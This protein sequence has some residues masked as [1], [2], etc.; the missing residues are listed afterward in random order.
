[1]A[2]GPPGGAG[3][4][5]RKPVVPSFHHQGGLG[6]DLGVDPP[7][8]RRAGVFLGKDR[9]HRPSPQEP[10]CHHRSH[11]GRH[12]PRPHRPRGV[13]GLSPS[14]EGVQGPGPGEDQGGIEGKEIADEAGEHAP[15]V[16]EV[17]RRKEQKGQGGEGAPAAPH[18]EGPPPD[19]RPR[20][21]GQEGSQ[22][23]GEVFQEEQVGGGSQELESVRHQ[24]G[25][26]G[27]GG[28]VLHGVPEGGEIQHRIGRYRQ[29]P[30]APR[31]KA[32][33]G[34]HPGPGSVPP[35]QPE[36]EHGVGD[37]QEDR[38]RGLGA[39]GKPPED[40]QEDPG[41]LAARGG[42]KRHV[43]G[44]EGLEQDPKDQKGLGHGVVGGLDEPRTPRPQ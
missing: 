12:G 9:G 3:K 20:D 40:P 23:P 11:Q 32:P 35:A 31:Q 15:H 43:G 34:P 25:P 21:Q 19:P 33:Q 39:Q 27:Q 30:R 28:L 42:R 4:E 14:E 5:G 36:E 29:G 44:H 26:L 13:T 8:R 10:R 2:V 1:M 6:G 24:K 38:R 16:G 41:S 7:A 37:D 17:D 18:G 22:V